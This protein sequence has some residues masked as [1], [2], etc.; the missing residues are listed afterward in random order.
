[1]EGS[2]MKSK[3]IPLLALLGFALALSAADK[4]WTEW[5]QKDAEKI[6]QDSNWAA[7]QTDADVSEQTYSPVP[8][9]V[10]G[11]GALNQTTKLNYTIHFLSAKPVRQAYLR[12]AE[13]NPSKTT[14]DQL[15]K[16]RQ[17][18]ATKE[19]EKVI[20]IAVRYASM[21]Q[22]F[23][24]SAHAVFS[25]A[26]TNTLKNNTYLDIKGG[27]T[28]RVFL[29]EYQAPV[30]NQ[31]LGAKFF[32]PRFI[33]DQPV[34][35]AKCSEVRFYAEFP[36]PTGNNRPVKLDMRFKVPKFLYEGVLEF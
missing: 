14:A 2:F 18:V 17:F 26:I 24:Q 32:F 19:F 15:E 16:M 3:L 29:Q 21:D 9:P 4:P 22:R 11:T 36:P 33:N 23:F 8:R 27:K 6:L 35:D 5:T 28:P 25:A 12:L 30:A 10:E 34:I 20:V 31:N 13:L 1:M 7:V